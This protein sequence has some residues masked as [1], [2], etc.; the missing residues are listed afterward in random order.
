MNKI[1][2]KPISSLGYNFVKPEYIPKGK[3]EYYLRN[4]QHRN[5]NQL[6]PSH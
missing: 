3:D 1:N 4:I 6:P 2:K 5:G